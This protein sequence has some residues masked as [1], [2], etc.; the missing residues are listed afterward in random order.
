MNYALLLPTTFAMRERYI[1]IC[2]SSIAPANWTRYAG[3]VGARTFQLTA[4]FYYRCRDSAAGRRAHLSPRHGELE[5]LYVDGR[6]RQIRRL[7]ATC[8]FPRDPDRSRRENVRRIAVVIRVTSDLVP[9]ADKFAP[10]HGAIGRPRFTV[11]RAARRFARD[12]AGERDLCA[13][14]ASDFAFKER[15]RGA[16]C[17][18]RRSFP[19]FVLP[20][21]LRE[22]IFAEFASRGGTRARVFRAGPS[23]HFLRAREN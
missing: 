16:T 15:L 14:L 10:P 5:R 17:G 3:H 7:H 1:Y 19:D 21:V 4:Y 9:I 11:I 13:G 22:G 20:N 2:I 8:T 6:R 23:M 18:R 12:E